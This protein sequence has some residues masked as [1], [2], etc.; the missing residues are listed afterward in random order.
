MDQLVEIWKMQ[1]KEQTSAS[2]IIA[3]RCATCMMQCIIKLGDVAYHVCSK[4]GATDLLL[5]MLLS[6]ENNDP[7]LQLSIL[8]LM[9][10][11]CSS[12][13]TDT[14][15]DT[16]PLQVATRDWLTSTAWTQPVIQ[17][18]QD[19]LLGGTAMQYLAM[20]CTLM[21]V[22][23]YADRLAPVQT[24]LFQYIREV[25]VITS[26]S[27]RLPIVQALSQI[28]TSSPQA[29]LEDPQLRH[30][31]WD[32]SR[33]S[34]PKLQAAIL[35][36]V[37][38]FLQNC[39]S[40]TLRHY[41]LLG[42][43]NNEYSDSTSW[44]V[45]FA[46]SP[47]P[48]LRIASYALWT[49]VVTQCAGGTTLLVTNSDVMLVLLAGGRESTPD[50]RLAKFEFLRAFFN[51]SQAFLAD[52]LRRNIEKQLQLGPHGIKPIPWADVAIE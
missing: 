3:V 52:D 11:E 45:K 12:S 29:V 42:P 31:W 39:E 10:Q 18:L 7:L 6:A 34:S 36:S 22:E 14:D 5:Q 37:A 32:M 30:A 25:G 9:V 13:A 35:S 40:T 2:S 1:L 26:E 20:T 46:K 21:G 24:A 8:D 33:L 17:L 27:D 47:I 48:E 23:D 43:D 16:P 50:G 19:P 38:Q 28:A 49:A 15:T 41:T 44:L 51:E 4:K